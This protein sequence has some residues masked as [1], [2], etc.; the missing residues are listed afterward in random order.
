MVSSAFLAATIASPVLLGLLVL[1]VTVRTYAHLITTVP[2]A[3]YVSADIV[4]MAVG[5]MPTAP[6]GMS[7]VTASASLFSQSVRRTLSAALTNS[8]S[9]ASA[10][11]FPTYATTRGDVLQ[12]LSALTEPVYLRWI[13]LNVELL[14]S[15]TVPP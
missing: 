15:T 5:L 3:K 6:R 4:L 7:A 2:M 14:T 13:S 1:T 11:L 12:A 8:A 9:M 10:S